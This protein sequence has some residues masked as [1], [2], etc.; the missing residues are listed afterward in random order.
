[1]PKIETSRDVATEQWSTPTGKTL[2]LRQN[3]GE[4]EEEEEEVRA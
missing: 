1:M 4:K 3:R 2:P